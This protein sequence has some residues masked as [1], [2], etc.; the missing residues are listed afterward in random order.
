[1]LNR[2]VIYFSDG[3][4]RMHPRRLLVATFLYSALAFGQKPE[5]DFYPEFRNNFIPKLRAGNPSVTNDEIVERYA[6]K[7]KSDDVADSEIAQRP[8]PVD[9][10]AGCTVESC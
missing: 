6:A 5:Y 4:H 8:K 2:R 10:V 1:M 3:R 7:F 9:G